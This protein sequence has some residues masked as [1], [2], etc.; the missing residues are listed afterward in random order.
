M[1]RADIGLLEQIQQATQGG[2]AVLCTLGRR[3]KALERGDPAR[4][5]QLLTAVRPHP[6][7]KSGRLAF[8]MLEVEDLMLDGDPVEPLSRDELVRSLN[9]AMQR[10]AGVGVSLREFGRGATWSGEAAP[11]TSGNGEGPADLPRIRLG[12]AESGN[13]VDPGPE[14]NSSDY[15]YDLVVLGFIETLELVMEGT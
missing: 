14:L 1:N 12:P 7:Y 8:D 9:G 2:R 6:L 10:W 4:A 5:A 15:L 13:G 11:T 3:G